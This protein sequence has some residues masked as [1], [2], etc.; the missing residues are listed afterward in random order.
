MPGMP[1]VPGMPPMPA[2]PFPQQPQ[3]PNLPTPPPSAPSSS[4]GDLNRQA[5]AAAQMHFQ[6]MMNAKQSFQAYVAQHAAY[7]A[8]QQW[9][10]EHS[11]AGSEAGYSLNDEDY[12]LKGSGSNRGAKSDYGGVSPSSAK[13]RRSSNYLQA[14]QAQAR[15]Q[16]RYSEGPRKAP[17]RDSLKPPP[18]PTIKHYRGQSSTSSIPKNPTK[19]RS[20]STLSMR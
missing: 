6:A 13:N 19:L 12:Y 5:A 8:G 9:D 17:S 4:S 18:P 14:Q 1:S 11:Q 2:Y 10:E 7:L 15:A 16:M 20:Q 3:Q